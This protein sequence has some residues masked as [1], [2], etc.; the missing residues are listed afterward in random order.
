MFQ[1]IT[2]VSQTKRTGRERK[3]SET[4]DAVGCSEVTDFQFLE[5]LTKTIRGQFLLR[6]GTTVTKSMYTLTLSRQSV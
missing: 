1:E 6:S 5:T 3:N 2:N 4:V